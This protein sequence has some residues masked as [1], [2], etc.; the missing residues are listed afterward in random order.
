L[1]QTIR[2]RP[3]FEPDL[4]HVTEALAF[5]PWRDGGARQLKAFR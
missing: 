3:P 4:E 5:T 1:Q 2:E